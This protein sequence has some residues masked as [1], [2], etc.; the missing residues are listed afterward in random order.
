MPIA[1]NVVGPAAEQQDRHSVRGPHKRGG[2]HESTPLNSDLFGY[3]TFSFCDVRDFER[4]NV[5]LIQAG[6]SHVSATAHGWLSLGSL[7][8]DSA[9]AMASSR[10]GTAS[11]GRTASIN[12]R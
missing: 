2:L 1:V 9:R 6:S 4:G 3:L 11:R 12:V 7:S 10:G 8:A 5:I